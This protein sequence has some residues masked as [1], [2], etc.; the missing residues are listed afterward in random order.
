MTIDFNNQSAC[1]EFYDL[2]L[3]EIKTAFTD[4]QEARSSIGF[5]YDSPGLAEESAVA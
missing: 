1:N 5:K 2:I 4:P 3:K